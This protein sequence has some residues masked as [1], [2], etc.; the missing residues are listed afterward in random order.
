MAGKQWNL[1]VASVAESHV[2]QS[3][4]VWR[5][6]AFAY[7]MYVVSRSLIRKRSH[8]EYIRAYNMLGLRE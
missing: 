5:F 3:W 4:D 7:A 6:A 2:A 1:L 8:V